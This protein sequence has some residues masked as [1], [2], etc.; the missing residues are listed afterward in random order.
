MS[1]GTPGST[2]VVN[3]GYGGSSRTIFSGQGPDGEPYF[4]DSEDRIVGDIL[5]HTD[6]IYN[7]ARR[8]MDEFRYTLDLKDP[9]AKPVPIPV[10]TPES[11]S[12]PSSTPK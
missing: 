11:R 2:I 8:T 7:P 1:L 9:N 12:E 6:R 3:G 10:P 5:H 4:R